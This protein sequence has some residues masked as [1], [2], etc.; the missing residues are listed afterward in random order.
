MLAASVFGGML[1]GGLVVG[2]LGDW[3][4][5]RPMLICGLCL[6]M[7]A[8]ILSALSPDV[9]VLTFLR[10][11]AGVGIGATVPPL[12]TLVAELA[13]PTK[14]G[15]CVTFCASFW[16]VGSVFVALVA[17]LFLKERSRGRGRRQQWKWVG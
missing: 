3:K 7:I 6:N 14:R 10:T 15:F 9:F 4:G 17:I 12:F 8:G 16:M 2:T 13:P 1:V 5:R 11:I